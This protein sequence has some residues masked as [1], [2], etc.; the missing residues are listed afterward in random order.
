MYD[1][2]KTVKA[3]ENVFMKTIIIFV[4]TGVKDRSAVMQI[5]AGKFMKRLWACLH[6]ND[7]V[8]LM[9]IHKIK[10]IAQFIF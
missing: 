9:H 5:N 10:A 4:D 7:A 1:R 8:D 3:D 6:K 2:T